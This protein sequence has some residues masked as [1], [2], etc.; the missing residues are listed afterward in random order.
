MSLVLFKR[1]L[2]DIGIKFFDIQK[3]FIDSTS[4][5]KIEASFIFN[6]KNNSVDISLEQQSAIKPHFLLE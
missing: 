4:C 6:R 2:R 3:N 1:L 5:P